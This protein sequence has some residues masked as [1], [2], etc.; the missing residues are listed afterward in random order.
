MLMRVLFGGLTLTLF[1]LP[2]AVF[3]QTTTPQQVRVPER[4]VNTNVHMGPTSAQPI[5]VLVPKGTVLPVLKKQGEWF[6]VQL[7]P[8]LRR[9][10]TPMRWY[11]NEDQGWVHESTGGS[12]AVKAPAE[13]GALTQRIRDPP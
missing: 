7:S 5:L 8:E 3:V 4:Q 6:A 9:L 2:A 11:K 10:G 1:L 13:T 12:C